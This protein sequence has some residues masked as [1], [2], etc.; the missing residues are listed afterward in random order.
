MTKHNPVLCDFRYRLAPQHPFPAAYEDSLSASKYIVTHAQ[1]LGV[2]PTR[3]ALMGKI[4]HVQHLKET[5]CS[6]HFFSSQKFNDSI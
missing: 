4:A 5:I 3:I 2:D 6:D 1:E